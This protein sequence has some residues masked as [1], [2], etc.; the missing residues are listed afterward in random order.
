VNANDIRDLVERARTRDRDA[1]A[2]LYR[3]A[4][5]GLLAFARRRVRCDYAAEDAVS[6]TMARAMVAIDAFVWRG[7]GFDA[8]LYGILRNVLRE[9]ARSQITLPAGTALAVDHREP[10]E[11]MIATEDAATVRSAF[12]R[13]PA[14]ERM[15]LELRVLARLPAATTGSLLGK[16][17]GA[18]RMAQSRALERLRSL[19]AS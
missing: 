11:T 17:A 1:W 5:P 14:D 13:L 15:L 4:H 7:N 6:E 10:V 19:L 9:H 16:R 2:S 18:V 3:R 8:W 12:E